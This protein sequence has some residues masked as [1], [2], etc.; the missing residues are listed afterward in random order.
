M[1]LQSHTILGSRNQRGLT[2]MT[3]DVLFRSIGQNI[4]R[5]EHP[6]LPSDTHL[7]PSL[8]ACDS[9]DAQIMSATCF[10]QS[11]YGDWDRHRSSRAQTPMYGGGSRA[12]TPMTVWPETQTIPG[13]FPSPPSMATRSSHNL[14]SKLP[15]VARDSGLFL[16][17]HIIR[18]LLRLTSLFYLHLS[19]DLRRRS[20]CCPLRCRSGTVSPLLER[21]LLK[22]ELQRNQWVRQTSLVGIYLLCQALFPNS[23]TFRIT[24]W[25]L[26]ASPITSFLFRCTRYTMI[27]YSICCQLRCS[28]IPA[29]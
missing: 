22:R 28:Q 6:E 9:S 21:N 20:L 7:V 24:E 18:A 17:C 26:T 19:A 8:Q 27:A 29:R 11:I 25:R 16:V 12:Q 3:L 13:S 23:P 1:N 2:Q 10:L 4:R 5:V 14:Y 15:S